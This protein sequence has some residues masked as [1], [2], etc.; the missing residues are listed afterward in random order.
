MQLPSRRAVF[1]MLAPNHTVIRY[2][3]RGNGLS[4]LEVDDISFEASIS[5][6]EAVIDDLGLES[7]ALIGQ[8]QGAAIA[9]AYAARNPEN[10]NKLILF[11]S[12][13]RGRRQR[14]SEGQ[15]AESDAFITMIREG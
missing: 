7:F 4:D 6:L 5:D 8:S 13:A 14:G 2:D 3:A 9:A 10:V 15:I 12:Y 1:D 11:G